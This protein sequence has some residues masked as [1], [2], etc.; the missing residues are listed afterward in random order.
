[1]VS[2]A[3]SKH[4]ACD[5]ALARCKAIQSPEAKSTTGLLAEFAVFQPEADQPS[6]LLGVLWGEIELMFP[7]PPVV[8]DPALLFVDRLLL[9]SRFVL[10]LSKLTGC[11]QIATAM[12]V[13]RKQSKRKRD[14]VQKT[15]NNAGLSSCRYPLSQRG[16]RPIIC[17][18]AKYGEPSKST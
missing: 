2:A 10:D 7:H 9:H 16:K 6:S 11:E 13:E 18:E 15:S 1:M 12:H 8:R 4:E 17:L 3:S 5:T 14:M